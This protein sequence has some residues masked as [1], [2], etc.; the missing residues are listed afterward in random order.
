[1]AIY[2]VNIT[3]IENNLIE[4]EATTEEEAINKALQQFEAYS[5]D[6]YNWFKREI[7]ITPRTERMCEES[8]GNRAN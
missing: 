7:S 3:Q 1:M 2:K 6:G 8:C 4:V 5:I